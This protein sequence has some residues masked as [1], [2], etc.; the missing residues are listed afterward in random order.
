LFLFSM[1]QTVS[2]KLTATPPEVIDSSQ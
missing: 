2:E 1:C